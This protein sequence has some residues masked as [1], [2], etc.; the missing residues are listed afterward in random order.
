MSNQNVELFA[1]VVHVSDEPQRRERRGRV[2]RA[3]GRRSN[4]EPVSSAVSSP[5]GVR[6]DVL[7][8]SRSRDRRPDGEPRGESGDRGHGSR[9]GKRS[10]GFCFT[11]NRPG[12]APEFPGTSSAPPA[13]AENSSDS[14]DQTGLGDSSVP[15]EAEVPVPEAD[16]QPADPFTAFWSSEQVRA[17]VDC[18]YFIVGD[19][20]APTTGQRHDQ[21]YFYFANP[22]ELAVVKE[23][24]R[25]HHLPLCERNIN[26][27]NLLFMRFDQVKFVLNHPLYVY[28][29][30]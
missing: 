23:I 3:R 24:L 21:G 25:F 27:K 13:P 19:E 17:T 29:S 11:F 10:R 15:A 20:T 7:P 16:Q 5:A 26:N 1:P 6:P 18:R 30:Y 28:N 12:L 2:G 22:R 14:G 8:R 4:R 9:R